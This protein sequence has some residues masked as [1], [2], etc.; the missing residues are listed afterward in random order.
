M[1]RFTHLSQN[2]G[3]TN[4]SDESDQQIWFD[5]F[6]SADAGGMR[7]NKFQDFLDA[8]IYQ[9]IGIAPVGTPD[10]EKN[11]SK[12]THQQEMQLFKTFDTKNDHALDFDEFS[13]MCHKWLDKV[14][15]PNSALVIVDVQNDFID[16]SLAL[17]NGPARQDG[18]E[19]VPIINDLLEANLFKTV[20]YTQD[21]HPA[22]HIG[23]HSNLYL[24]RYRLKNAANQIADKFETNGSSPKGDQSNG[25]GNAQ[26]A[27]AS[28][29]NGPL[30]YKKLN[31]EVKVFDTVIF[32]D[33]QTEQKMWPTHCVQ[34]SWGAQLH[35]KLRV[36]KDAIYI[37]KGASSN[38]D[39]Y[40]AFWDNK[41]LN[42]T[43]LRQELLS[44]KISDLY[45]CGL[46]LDYCVAASA[47][48]SAT[49]G[50]VTY[51]VEDACRC[52]DLDE[53]E[54]RKMDMIEHGIVIVNCEEVS[55]FMGRHGSVNN[56]HDVSA[57]NDGLAIKG[58]LDRDTIKSI[59]FRRA[60]L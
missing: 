49:A 52:I 6:K 7:F 29:T 35:H 46:A 44:R 21:W 53:M 54:R 10:G 27:A 11:S 26:M 38:V 41:R 8:T 40:S 34:N 12:F 20:I 4:W 5:Q 50:F 56:L 3:M 59:C 57:D 13:N 18:A 1:S 14:Y 17:V 33:G 58:A 23:F 19:V 36:V 28:A 60:F 39:A 45:F 55:R 15:K 30:K 51:V 48:D 31:S 16:G 47:M 9:Y 43:G 42:E 37:Q 24:R 22:D 2:P 32:D 25:D